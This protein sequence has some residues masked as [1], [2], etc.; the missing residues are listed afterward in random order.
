MSRIM[1]VVNNTTTT[2]MEKNNM[3]AVEWFFEM[4]AHNNILNH[5]LLCDNK[6]LTELVYKLKNEAKQR[7]EQNI[8]MAWTDGHALGKNGLVVV[9]YS[10]A[11]EY[12]NKNHKK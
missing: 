8:C 7:E 2:L 9:D 11:K 1:A 6:P 12:Y 10:N 4:L 5:K 3:T